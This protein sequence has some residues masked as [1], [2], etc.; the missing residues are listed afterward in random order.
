MNTKYR[1]RLEPFGQQN[2]ADLI[3]WINNAEELMQFGGPLFK[4]PITEELTFT[5][6]YKN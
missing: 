1:I 4:F 2:Y 6:N 3:S 5:N